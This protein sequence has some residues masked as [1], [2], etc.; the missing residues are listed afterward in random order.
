MSLG[1]LEAFIERFRVYGFIRMF[2][3]LLSAP[4]ELQHWC[5]FLT[6]PIFFQ[7]VSSCNWV[8]NFEI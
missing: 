5:K 8:L 1:V 7:Y 4:L 6:R 3:F 2:F